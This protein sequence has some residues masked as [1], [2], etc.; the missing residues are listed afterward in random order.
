MNINAAVW[1]MVLAC[2]SGKNSITPFIVAFLIVIFL[3]TINGIYRDK[4]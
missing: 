3:L 1:G 2:T 4:K